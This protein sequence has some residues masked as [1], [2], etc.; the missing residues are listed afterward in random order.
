MYPRSV[1]KFGSSD[2][3]SFKGCGKFDLVTSCKSTDPLQ[4][5]PVIKKTCVRNLLVTI[6]CW[7]LRG[8]P[9]SSTIYNWL[10]INKPKYGRKVTIIEITNYK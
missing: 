10:V 3:M 7:S 1:A 2:L 8:N 4:A 6:R 9:V 5:R